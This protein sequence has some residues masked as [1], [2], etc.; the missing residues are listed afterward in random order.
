MAQKGFISDL[1]KNLKE[2]ASLQLWRKIILG[3][4]ISE[5]ESLEA[6]VFQPFRNCQ[7]ASVAVAEYTRKQGQ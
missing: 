2:V 6:G 1:N 5:Y 4:R 3:R 7:E